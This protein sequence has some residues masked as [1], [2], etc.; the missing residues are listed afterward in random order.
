MIGA[1]LIMAYK[2]TTLALVLHLLLQTFMDAFNNMIEERT[3]RRGRVGL[4]GRQRGLPQDSR[5]LR[6]ILRVRHRSR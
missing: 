6:V 1:E 2:A 5:T 3:S 4:H